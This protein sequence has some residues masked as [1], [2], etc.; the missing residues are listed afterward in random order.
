MAREIPRRKLDGSFTQP[1]G[2]LLTYGTSL[3]DS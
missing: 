3:F 1:D 2:I